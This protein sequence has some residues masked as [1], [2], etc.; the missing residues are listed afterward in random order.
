MRL[1]LIGLLVAIVVTFGVVAAIAAVVTD[2]GDSAGFDRGTS[3]RQVTADPQRYVGEVVT[4]SGRVGEALPPDGEPSAVVLGGD[5]D[6]RLLVVPREAGLLPEE[7]RGGELDRDVFLRVTGRV[8]MVGREAQDAPELVP[9]AGMIARFRG[10]PAVLA[11]EAL[12]VG[13]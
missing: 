3:L 11:F 7:I 12:V 5:T 10:Q 6:E 13:E 4:V 9:E 2:E 8:Q 1:A